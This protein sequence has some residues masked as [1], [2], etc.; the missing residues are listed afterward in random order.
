MPM[1]ILELIPTGLG[2]EDINKEVYNNCGS[3]KKSE[4]K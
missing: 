3:L 2:Q 4:E 1:G